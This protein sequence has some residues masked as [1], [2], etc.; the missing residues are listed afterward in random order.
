[1]QA[2]ALLLLAVLSQVQQDQPFKGWRIQRRETNPKSHQQEIVALIEGDEA[3]PLNTTHGK[4]LFDIKGLRL[5]YFTDPKRLG[6]PSEEIKLRSD[7]ARLDNQKDRADLFGHVH[8]EKLD[9]STLDAPVAVLLFKKRYLCPS[10][11]G[12]SEKPGQCPACGADLKPRTYTTIEAP[13]DFVMV[14][15]EP[16]SR[17]LGEGLTANDDLRELRIERNG[18]LVT[19]GNGHDLAPPAPRKGHD[20]TAPPPAPTAAEGG[21]IE[22]NSKGPMTFTQDEA[23]IVVTGEREVRLRR[24]DPG[25]DRVDFTTIESDALN[26]RARKGADPARDEPEPERVDARGHVRMETRDGVARGTQLAWDRTGDGED[27]TVLEGE[28]AA[29]DTGDNHIEARTVTIHRLTGVSNFKDEVTAVFAPGR[30]PG[31][32]PLHLQCRH[33]TTQAA[34]GGHEISDLEAVG[35]V[36]LEGLTQGAGQKPGRALAD[37]FAWDLE[38]EHGLLEQRQFVRIFQENSVIFAPK[39]ILEGRSSIILKGP[40]R[41]VLTQRD[42]DGAEVPT[43]VTSAGDLVLDTVVDRAA[44]PPTERKVIRLRHECELRRPDLQLFADRMTVTTAKDGREVEAI[45]ASGRVRAWQVKE[46]STMFGEWLHLVPKTEA[47]PLTMTLTG[48]PIAIV[49]SGRTVARQEMIVIREKADATGKMVQYQEMHGGKHGVKIVADERASEPKTQTPGAPGSEPSKSKPA[50]PVMKVEPPQP[51]PLPPDPADRDRSCIDRA[52]EL[53]REATP[54]YM[55]IAEELESGATGRGPTPAIR[56]K[57]EE[58]RR[59]LGQA[60]LLYAEA[61]TG[62]PD[63][64]L[65]EGR[66]RRLD[67]LLDTLDRCVE[68]LNSKPQ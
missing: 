50:R 31:D 23:G 34:P 63:P 33:L 1:M 51:A 39:V 43:T 53:I 9:G 49:E 14:R 67:S 36:I 35:D 4:E 62:A 44:S 2:P 55:E 24:A 52:A 32:Q 38:K 66:L 20:P 28:R 41:V 27:V 37:R 13:K 3:L 59:R 18:F 60:R 6:D 54:L 17:L 56:G 58:V 10:D 64:P 16:P 29:V 57:V 40:K 12:H 21:L 47:R 68:Q 61:L 15:S 22:M 25:T 5:R 65:I 8:V 46:G 11:D 19:T 26:L 42:A 45:D 48:A 30:G 7:T